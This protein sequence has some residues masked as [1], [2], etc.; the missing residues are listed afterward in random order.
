[1]T[2]IQINNITIELY[3]GIKELPIQRFKIFQ[4]YLLQDSGIGNTMEDIDK[5][6]ANTIMFL[7]ADKKTEAKEELTNVRY[8]F[9][10]LLNGIDYKTKSFAC[11]V[12]KID[13]LEYADLS[14]EGLDNVVN[15]LEEIGA[16]IEEIQSHWHQ[17]KK[18]LIPS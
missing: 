14:T 13:G 1:M 12:K 9:Y 11:L 3:S 7:G 18:N 4:N 15:K 16:T 5:H 8:T 6:L 17:V 2:T 10:S